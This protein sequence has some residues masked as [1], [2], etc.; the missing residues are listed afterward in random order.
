MDQTGVGERAGVWPAKAKVDRVKRGGPADAFVRLTRG[1]DP[2]VGEDPVDHRRLG[3]ER[4]DPHDPTADPA[5]QRVDFEHLLS[6]AI[7]LGHPKGPSHTAEHGAAERLEGARRVLR[8]ATVPHL[9]EAP[10]LLHDAKGVLTTRPRPRAGRVDP[11]PVGGAFAALVHAIVATAGF[12]MELVLGFAVR[13]VAEE[14]RLA[15]AHQVRELTDIGHRRVGRRE[16]VHHA[17]RIG[18]DMN[19]HADVP[20]LA[21]ARLLHLGI[22]RLRRILRRAGRSNDRRVDNRARLQQQ[23]LLGEQRLHR[24][25][26]RGRQLMLLSEMPKPQDRRLIGHRILAQLHARKAPHRF[27]VVQHVLRLRIGEIEPLLQ[28]VHAQHRLEREWASAPP[29]LGVVRLDPCAQRR[30][31]NHGDQLA[32]KPLPPRDLP[33]GVIHHARQR[34]LLAHPLLRAALKVDISVAPTLPPRQKNQLFAESP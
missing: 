29:R 26:H 32:E 14:R 34:P 15:A 8:E 11:I 13:L 2:E 5:R 31:G 24:L 6:E 7:V 20:L 19:L 25:K 4:D 17:A 10:E 30:P 21:F 27:R 9:R 28:E 1:A 33:L 16:R 22:A 3:D 18:A 23:P 12:P